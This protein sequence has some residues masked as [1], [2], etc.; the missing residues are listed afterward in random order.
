VTGYNPTDGSLRVRDFLS[1]AGFV[2][3][4]NSQTMIATRGQP[5]SASQLVPNSLVRIWFGSGIERRDARKI[6]I[7]AIPG[8]AFSF[9]GTITFVDFR[10]GYIV[11]AEQPGIA[12]H[13]IAINNLPSDTK[14]RLK[15]GMDVT[16]RAK[17]DGKNYE[18]RS[19][20]NTS[21]QQP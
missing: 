12:T 18:A 7:L 19:I 11:I 15:E 3:R 9:A 16:V 14:L 13:E 5:S 10:A 21:N 17:F 4:L 1:G 6:D 8:E 2:V 20:E